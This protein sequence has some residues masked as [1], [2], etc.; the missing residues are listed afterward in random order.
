MM[1]RFP[2][3]ANAFLI[4]LVTAAL[5][6][7]AIAQQDEKFTIQ[8][9]D[10]RGAHIL[11]ASDL[12][13]L[14]APYVGPNRVFGDVQKALDAVEAAYR[15][16]GYSAVQVIVPEQELNQGV[17]RFEVTETPIG[18]VTVSGNKAFSTENIRRSLPALR[19][20]ETPNGRLISESVQLANENPAK[21]VEVVLGMG[22]K[23]GTV[24]ARVAVTEEPIQR[25][26][27]TADNSGTRPTGRIRL[28]ATYQHA[29]LFDRDQT[30][31][32]SY[33]TSPNKDIGI[34]DRPEHTKVDVFSVGYR[35]PFYD[36]GDSLDLIYAY[37]N[38]TTPSTTAPTGAP[39]GIAVLGKGEIV[40]ARWNHYFAR[41]GEYSSRLILG[42]DWKSV[43]SQTGGC[44][45][46]SS[47]SCIKYVTS[48]LSATYI[49]KL[50]KPGKLLD[51]SLGLAHN[52]P[53][54]SRYEYPAN[55]GVGDRFSLAAGNRQSRDDFTIL[56]A[57]FSYSDTVFHDWLLRV[58][59]NGQSSLGSALV[60]T[61][62]IGLAGSNA[63]RGFLER[64]IATDSGV[65]GNIELYTPELAPKFGLARGNLRGLVFYDTAVGRLHNAPADP[66]RRLS[67]WGVGLR[68]GLNKD[69]SVKFDVAQILDYGPPNESPHRGS[70]PTAGGV[71][72][73]NSRGDSRAH[74][75]ITVGF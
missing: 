58:A 3:S 26:Y 41:R 51:Y 44:A 75:S 34:D 48:P 20:G 13:R 19:E 37:S 65:V 71:L 67:S 1:T 23:E 39:L 49:G 52:I 29:N 17:V 4:A 35:M 68:Y 21:Q 28:G 40:A 9:F 5:P 45:I 25:W 12:A 73:T 56:K 18:A 24:D 47:A 33:L 16:A 63:V 30:L 66:T 31:S 11:S 72:D 6:H 46:G 55:S 53:M 70:D 50:E 27:L 7:A 69:V 43:D 8:R 32:V 36:I 2:A 57:S 64:I 10:V 74:L 14:T 15:D 22:K 60:S 42:F 61:E 54:G 38:A 59:A 62:Q